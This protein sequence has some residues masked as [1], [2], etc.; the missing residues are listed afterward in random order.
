MLTVVTGPP[1]SGK[2]A[3]VRERARPGDVVIDFDVAAQAFGSPVGHDHP[4][5]VLAVA[6]AAWWPAVRAALDCHRRGA[7]VWVV[8]TDPP[9]HRRQRY[10]IAG[11]AFVRLSAPPAELARRAAERADRASH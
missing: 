6:R 11:A 7:R 3:Y 4:A 8:D 9:S 2:S 10:H 1:C 5:A